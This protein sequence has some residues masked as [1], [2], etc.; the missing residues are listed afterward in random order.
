MCTYIFWG[1]GE[2]VYKRLTK[3]SMTLEAW[4][5]DNTWLWTRSLMCSLTRRSLMN[6]WWKGA[7]TNFPT[8]KCTTVMMT[9]DNPVT[10][11]SSTGR[12]TSPAPDTQC[13]TT[14]IDLVVLLQSLTSTTALPHTLD[15][16]C[17]DHSPADTLTLPQLMEA[18]LQQVHTNN[19]FRLYYYNPSRQQQFCHIL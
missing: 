13:H 9:R 7:M 3:L 4:L 19:R 12:P 17:P 18:S 15:S 2:G 14:I 8:L 6:P 1:G 10:A 16:H 5:R 11:P